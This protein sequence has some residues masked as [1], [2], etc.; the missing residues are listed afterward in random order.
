MS[1]MVLVFIFFQL[2]SRIIDVKLY[3][4]L[5]QQNLSFSYR[6]IG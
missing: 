1:N 5:G 4:T 3:V 2:P 6:I